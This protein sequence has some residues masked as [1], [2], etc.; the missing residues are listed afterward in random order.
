MLKIDIDHYPIIILYVHPSDWNWTD[1][2]S[3]HDDFTSLIEMADNNGVK[4]RLV[5]YGQPGLPVQPSARF[6][7]QVIKDVTLKSAQFRRV[8][9]KIGIYKP[10]KGADNFVAILMTFFSKIQI[11]KT[12]EE[13]HEFVSTD[14]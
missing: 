8:F 2:Q 3:F 14:N 4:L 12:K 9:E 7:L 5:V 10:N 11:F 1:Y 6:W 13:A